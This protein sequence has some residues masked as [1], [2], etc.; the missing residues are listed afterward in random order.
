MK[1]RDSKKMTFQEMSATEQQLLED[2]ETNTSRRQYAEARAARL[3][4]FRGKILEDLET[5]EKDLPGQTKTVQY[6]IDS[7]RPACVL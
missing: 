7:I 1:E 4:S 3:P 2:F 5:E 6:S